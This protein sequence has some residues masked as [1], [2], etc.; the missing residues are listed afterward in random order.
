MLCPAVPRCSEVVKEADGPIGARRKDPRLSGVERHVKYPGVVDNVMATQHLDRHDERV[1]HQVSVHGAVEHVHC[2]VV[3]AACKE[4]VGAVEGA[5]A[6]RVVVV[7]QRLVRLGGQVE[8]VPREPLVLGA[9]N[10]VVAAGVHR[11]ARDAAGAANELLGE[12]LLRQ[13]VHTHVVL[14]RHKEEGL[15]GVERNARHAAAVLFERVLRRALGQ[16][17]HQHRL[18]VAR[19]RDG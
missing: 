9:H 3:A 14:R 7:P 17:V 4:R 8:V 11:Q 18:S 2:G 1:A 15:G 16:L 19:G 6:H 10:D 5:P 13:V 12:R